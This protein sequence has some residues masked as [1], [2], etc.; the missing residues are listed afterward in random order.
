MRYM[1]YTEQRLRGA[2]LRDGHRVFFPIIL[3]DMLSVPMHSIMTPSP[4]PLT[5][6]LRISAISP[7]RHAILS[8]VGLIIAGYR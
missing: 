1:V 8:V 4:A 7:T 5:H 2:S 3:L 6:C